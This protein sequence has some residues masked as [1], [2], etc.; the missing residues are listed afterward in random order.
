VFVPQPALA[1]YQRDDARLTHAPHLAGLLAGVLVFARMLESTLAQVTQTQEMP[2]DESDQPGM[3]LVGQQ[4]PQLRAL[5]REHGILGDDIADD[6]NALPGGAATL[7]D[8]S[9]LSRRVAAR[10]EWAGALHLANSVLWQ[11]CAH[12]IWERRAIWPLLRS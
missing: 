3:P 5:A 11:T 4:V 6:G 8:L 7:S 12:D 10:A 2:K 1:A 9:E